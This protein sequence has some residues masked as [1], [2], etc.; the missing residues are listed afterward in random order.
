MNSKWIQLVVWVV[1]IV[2]SRAS[3]LYA[4]YAVTPDL[5]RE[6][7][8]AVRVAGLEWR[9]LIALQAIVVVIL[10]GLRYLD[11]FA[12]R[13]KTPDD[14]H[15][16]FQEFVAWWYMGR[17]WPAWKCLWL[18]SRPRTM[19]ACMKIAGYVLVGALVVLGFWIAAAMLA[20]QAWPLAARCY[21]FKVVGLSLGRLSPLAL[22]IPIALGLHYWSLRREY[23]E[24]RNRPAHEVAGV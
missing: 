4:T 16:S 14:A 11:L 10:V 21:N 12:I 13:R 20:A 19:R 9:G 5:A 15:L 18:W 6:T 1:L 8:P 22:G 7:N 24:Y 3:D 17:P 2:G 23:T